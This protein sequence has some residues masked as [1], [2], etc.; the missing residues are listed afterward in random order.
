[1]TRT[2]RRLPTMLSLLAGY[3]ILGQASAA[4]QSPVDGEFGLALEA[5]GSILVAYPLSFGSIPPGVLRV[6]PVTGAVTPVST[7]TIGN[8]PALSRPSEIAVEAGGTAV[9]TDSGGDPKIIRVDPMS[10]DRT[11]VSDATTGNGPALQFPRGIAV[12]TD[13]SLFVVD[14]GRTAEDRLFRVDP[15]TGDRTIVSSALVGE[16]PAL[17]WARDVAIEAD[18]RLL[19]GDAGDSATPRVADRI[20]RVDPGTGDRSDVSS[21]VIGDGPSLRGPRGIDWAPDGSLVVAASSDELL[22]CVRCP[23]LQ[24][25]FCLSRAAS[26]VRVDPQT[27]DRSRISGGGTCIGNGFEALCS[28]GLRGVG[29]VMWK[30]SDVAVERDGSILVSYVG[31]ATSFGNHR[32]VMR[33]NANTGRRRILAH[34]SAPGPAASPISLRDAARARFKERVDRLAAQHPERIYRATDTQAWR[35]QP[36]DDRL[37]MAVWRTMRQVLGDEVA[38]RLVH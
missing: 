24:C 29:P 18:G 35:G 13:G 26:V 27:G 32:G 25:E 1:M 15:V 14:G 23:Y 11:V 33:I 5:D 12:A 6:D 34:F 20:V 16:G 2:W 7:A 19:M 10:G 38:D 22:F 17:E 36:V 8:G 21:G 28:F 37:R 4:A 31:A 3:L 30:A 9:V